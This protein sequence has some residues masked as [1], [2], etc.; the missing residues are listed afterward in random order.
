MRPIY[1]IFFFIFFIVKE[2]FAQSGDGNFFSKFSPALPPKV[3]AKYSSAMQGNMGLLN[4]TGFK[5]GF[6][7]R[8]NDIEFSANNQ[9]PFR[10]MQHFGMGIWTRG[11]LTFAKKRLLLYSDASIGYCLFYFPYEQRLGDLV[12][13]HNNYLGYYYS[14]ELGIRYRINSNFTIELFSPNLSVKDFK[15]VKIEQVSTA[16]P[17]FAMQLI[18]TKPW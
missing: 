8:Y 6:N 10:W 1:L 13:I 7:G 14:V 11:Y 16:F 5:L 12:K 18:I 9:T 3:T 4:I 17:T 15:K 2:T